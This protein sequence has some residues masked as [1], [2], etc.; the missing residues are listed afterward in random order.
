VTTSTKI[1]GKVKKTVLQ[2][3]KYTKVQSVGLSVC[4]KYYITATIN[5]L[6]NTL[7]L[8][9]LLPPAYF[10]IFPSTYLAILFIWMLVAIN[11]TFDEQFGLVDIG[12]RGLEERRTVCKMW[13]TGML[14]P[15]LSMGINAI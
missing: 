13:E 8:L 10:P 4:A 7:K 6:H 5:H 2:H 9:T 14:S 1:Q 15:P 11:F 3:R 12:H